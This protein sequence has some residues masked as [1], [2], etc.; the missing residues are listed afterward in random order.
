MVVDVD[1]PL[2]SDAHGGAGRAGVADHQ[3]GSAD[4]HGGH[5]LG[6]LDAGA[7]HGV[8]HAA[9]RAQGQD[10]RQGR[11]LHQ[12]HLG[13]LD[14]EI[15]AALDQV[16][17]DFGLAALE[18]VTPEDDV[19]GL[20]DIRDLAPHR[21]IGGVGIELERDQLGAVVAAQ[22][23][24]QPPLVCGADLTFDPDV[25][26]HAG[27]ADPHLG[28]VRVDTEG[29]RPC[30]A[31]MAAAGSAQPMAGLLQQPARVEVARPCRQP[32][33]PRVQGDFQRAFEGA[34]QPYVAGLQQAAGSGLPGARGVQD[35]A[36]PR[37]SDRCRLHA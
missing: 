11:C 26:Q 23:D 32:R 2:R 8:G 22:R 25:V 7:V 16:A 30:P 36:G 28:E 12:P 27:I 31:L 29:L 34:L 6:E 4:A 9:Q 15:G 21:H 24:V 17:G 37:A 19:A 1:D 5:H 35:E 14:L 3:P 20:A 13:H 33:A 18:G 10:P